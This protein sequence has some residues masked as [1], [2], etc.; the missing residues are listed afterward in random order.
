MVVHG[1][2]FPAAAPRS[3]PFVGCD[4]PYQ[5]TAE[6]PQPLHRDRSRPGAGRRAQP[7]LRPRR[8]QRDRLDPL[9][10]LGPS[11]H[12]R[13]HVGDSAGGRVGRDVRRLPG[14]GRPRHRSGVVR[15]RAALGRGRRLA[16]RR[17]RRTGRSPGRSSTCS[18][19]S[20]SA[21]QWA[22]AKIPAFVKAH[23][24]DGPGFFTIG[25]GCDGRSFNMDAWRIGSPGAVA[26][27]DLE[28]LTTVTSISGPDGAIEAGDP[29]L[30]QRVGDRRVGRPDR[31]LPVGAG[32]PGTG[33]RLG[34]RRRR[35]WRRSGAH[36]DA[37]ED[38]DLPLA[39]RRSPARC[40][41]RVSA[42]HRRRA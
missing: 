14:A 10:R 2:T 3:S 21:N 1:T 8:R 7:R 41:Q 36:G 11:D 15:T 4:N 17:R 33:R 26:T 20:R 37:R 19:S 32:S 24:G 38:H 35:Q 16:A 22:E 29:V 12:G 13:G 39:F 5:L 31:G 25:F 34:D 6:Q 18:V 28:G 40:G 27:Y 30:L 9:R 23:G 42:V